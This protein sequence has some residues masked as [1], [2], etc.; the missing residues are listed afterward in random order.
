MKKTLYSL[1]LGFCLGFGVI[2]GVVNPRSVEAEVVGKI[3]AKQVRVSNDQARAASLKNNFFVR[4]SV[5]KTSKTLRSDSKSSPATKKLSGKK[6]TKKRP[7]AK[8]SN[9][10]QASRGKGKNQ[11]P[12]RKRYSAA[13]PAVLDF[14]Q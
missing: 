10:K 6:K 3:R 4:K 8:I 13:K 11:K 12:N 9:Q 5:A 1:C 2:A 14:T 7:V